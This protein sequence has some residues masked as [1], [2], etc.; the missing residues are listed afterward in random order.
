MRLVILNNKTPAFVMLESHTEAQPMEVVTSS[1][2]I[3]VAPS[4]TR[5]PADLE[6]QQACFSVIADYYEHSIEWG[7]VHEDRAICKNCNRL[8]RITNTIT[9]MQVCP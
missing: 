8:F 2:P 6:E 9:N 3:K 7:V 1:G 4:Q 5:E